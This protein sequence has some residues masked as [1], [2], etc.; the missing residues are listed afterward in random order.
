MWVEF[1][2]S[3][4]EKVI[5]VETHDAANILAMRRASGDRVCQGL[6]GLLYLLKDIELYLTRT[7]FPSFGRDL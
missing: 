3:N 4:T 2:I 7:L 1:W 5:N 6:Y